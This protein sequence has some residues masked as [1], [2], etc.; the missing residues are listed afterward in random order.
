VITGSVFSRDQ[1]ERHYGCHAQVI[2]PGMSEPSEPDLS[3][4]PDVEFVFYPANSWRHKNHAFLLNTWM[5]QP[6]LHS[7]ALV[8]TMSTGMG[9]LQRQIAEARRAGIDVRVLGHVTSAQVAGLYMRARCAVFPSLYEGYGLPVH[10]ALRL[11]CPILLNPDAP[12]LAECVAPDYPLLLALDSQLWARSI[13]TG[14]RNLTRAWRDDIRGVTWQES[15]KQLL[16]TL[17][18]PS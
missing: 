1:L 12:S 6:E 17:T 13:V 14:P 10:E 8:F 3:Q 4:S 9:P 2:P 18:T 16:T 15:G 11:G 5:S 7:Y